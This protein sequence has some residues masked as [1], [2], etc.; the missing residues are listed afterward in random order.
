LLP[1]LGTVWAIVR[2]Q[3]TPI[4][5]AEYRSQPTLFPVRCGPYL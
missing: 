1:L 4:L 5:C 2:P 3:L